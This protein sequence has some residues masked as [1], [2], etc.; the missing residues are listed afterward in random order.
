VYLIALI[1][2]SF[3]A[4]SYGKMA[5][6]F[7]EAGSSYAYASKGLHPIAG[8]FTG[9][10]MILDYILMPMLCVIIAAVTSH[11]LVPAIPYS[12]WVIGTAT[13]ITSINLRGIEMTSRAT[14]VFN[15]VL[16]ASVLWFV[17][18][19]VWA[20]QHGVGRSTLFSL[21][22]F[23]SPRTFSLKAIM[24]ATPMAVLS[25]L[26]FDGISTLAEDAKAPEK[27]VGRATMLVCLI[28]G[29]LFILQT[30]LGQLVWPDYTTFTPLETAFSSIGHL[31]GGPGLAYLI[32]L[33]VIGQAWASGITSQ[34][35]A[36]RLLF[37]MARGG[38][39]PHFI[40]G[41]L[42]HKRHTPIY[43]MILMG[44]IAM[45][46]SLFLNLDNAAEL[47][48]FG[49]CAGFM[50]VNLS[51]ISHYFFRKRNRNG[52]AVVT[53]LVF[54]ALGF[55]VCLW[56]WLS[57]SVLAMKVGA[58]WSVAGILYLAI[59]IRRSGVDLQKGVER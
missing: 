2:V 51:V 54:P 18:A 59:L 30:Y 53:S 33:L 17:V 39:L 12:A 45:I 16:S 25:F 5:A 6:A 1:A 42:H 57:V 21:E 35:S 55:G 34:A 14:L 4:I 46:A 38:L 58:I 29:I 9:W 11:K 49:A 52:K 43:S 41:H 22:P 8:Y 56:I 27:N 7:P 19:A 20:L 28:A 50:A 32:A 31:V 23:Y 48:N 40:F 24:A 36:S 13:I 3:T 26:G 37:G 15:L 47:T 44:A 10:L